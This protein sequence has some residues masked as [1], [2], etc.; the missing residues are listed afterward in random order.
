MAERL[1]VIKVK[2]DTDA[3]ID[4]MK[5]AEEVF[6]RKAPELGMIFSCRAKTD[7]GV[8]VVNLWP[9]EESS[10]KAFQDPEI[11][12]ALSKFNAASDGPSDR[13][14]YEVFDYRLIG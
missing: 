3:L 4:A 14:H 7:D 2:G 8:M 5:G 9:D 6:E 13:N 12:E 10:E 1:T 11:Q